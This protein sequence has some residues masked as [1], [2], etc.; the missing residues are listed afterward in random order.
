MR[1]D[2]WGAKYEVNTIFLTTASDATAGATEG[3]RS[4]GWSRDVFVVS[5]G[6]NGS[7]DTSLYLSG[8][9]AASDDVIYTVQGASR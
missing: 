4:G 1:A 2:P 3:L 9:T 5:A 6:G 8:S 7:I